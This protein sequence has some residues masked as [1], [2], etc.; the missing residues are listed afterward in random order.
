M[1]AVAR[2]THS[3]KGVCLFSTIAISEA[4][5]QSCWKMKGM[6]RGKKERLL[7]KWGIP[8]CRVPI[9]GGQKLLREHGC[10]PDFN[11]RDRSNTTSFGVLPNETKMDPILGGGWGMRV[12]TVFCLI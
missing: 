5:A 2:E 3:P 12:T 8:Y 10:H 9:M 11:W 1:I 7:A 6:K 4:E